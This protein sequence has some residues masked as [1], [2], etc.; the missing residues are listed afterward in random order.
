VCAGNVAS[1]AVAGGG[2]FCWGPDGL[3][4]TGQGAVGATAGSPLSVAGLTTNASAVS[5]LGS[6]VCALRASGDVWCW[7]SGSFD[8]LGRTGV[9]SSGTAMPVPGV[10][11]ALRVAAGVS[12]V[13]AIVEPQRQAVCWGSNTLGQLGDP[14]FLLGQSS[15]APRTVVGMTSVTALAASQYN[16]CAVRDDGTLWCWGGSDV[17][18]GASPWCGRLGNGGSPSGS[19]APVRV[20]AL[21]DFA[22]VVAGYNHF[23]ALRRNGQLLCWG[24]NTNHEV[25]AT[26][27]E[28]LTPVAVQSGVARVAAGHEGTCT[29]DFGNVV[30]CWGVNDCHQRGPSDNDPTLAPELIPGYP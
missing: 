10:T 3:G 12:H 4:E 5:C 15:A 28:V 23:C 14:T 24:A 11:G 22:D 27:G 7:G 18:C 16:T 26:A 21:S 30:R 9:T 6:T 8:Q 2:V 19:D 29:L 1:C 17:S 20:G 25:S 13:C